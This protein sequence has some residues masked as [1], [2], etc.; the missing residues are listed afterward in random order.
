LPHTRGSASETEQDGFYAQW[1]FGLADPLTIVVGARASDFRVR[2]RNIPPAAPTAWVAGNSADD[3]ITPY[4]GIVYDLNAWLSLYA[5]YSTIFIPQST[6]LKA[7]SSSLDPRTGRQ[8]EVGSKA[9]FFDRR[10]TASVAVFN[11]RD[12]N[13]SLSDVRNPGFYLNAGEVESKGWEAQISGS[14]AAGYEVQAG[15][16]RGDNRYRVAAPNQQGLQLSLFEPRHSWKLWGVRRFQRP[17]QAGLTL[18]LGV[19][20]QSGIRVEPNR[21]QG[22]YAVVSALVGYRFDPHVE[23]DL[24]LRNVFDKT[25]YP[26]LGGTNSYNTYG[27]PASFSLS[28]RATL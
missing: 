9:D 26:R 15:Y 7:D 25:Y 6:L 23:V 8:Y 10:L 21:A 18:G 19:N 14:P 5:S 17:D 24:N 3:E 22:G 2:S 1:R 12:V 20:A 4:G 28:L 11:L 13:R 27:E 16:A